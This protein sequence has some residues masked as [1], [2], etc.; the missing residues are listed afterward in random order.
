MTTREVRAKL[1][2]ISQQRVSKLVKDGFLVVED[3]GSGRL[4]YDRESVESLARIRA[5]KRA[6]TPEQAEERRIL[7]D[8]ASER[9]RRARDR[10]RAEAAERQKH[11]D[12][13]YE[14]AVLALEK[15]AKK[16]EWPR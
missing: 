7:H 4:K 3:D 10:E 11:L 15:I 14:R 2:A 9:F 13:L 1:G 5:M 8:E 16:L 6:E 12:E